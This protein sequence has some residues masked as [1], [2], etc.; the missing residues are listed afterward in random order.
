MYR[1]QD[2]DRATGQCVTTEF[3]LRSDYMIRVENSQQLPDQTRED[4][5]GRASWPIPKLGTLK[6][7][8]WPY[9][10]WENFDVLETDYTNYAIVYT[11][12]TE[13]GA[14]TKQYLWILMR[15]P[16]E[17]QS[18]LWKAY[19]SVSIAAIKRR[20]TD[21]EIADKLAD[22]NADDSYMSST[23]QGTDHCVYPDDKDFQN[24]QDYS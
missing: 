17:P 12:A 6:V 4:F 23:L 7:K 2:S 5:V 22:L 13:Y 1:P 24:P 8:Y 10:P 16:A 3:L 15:Q 19:Q 14:W 21:P 20:F 11:C 9:S 18:K